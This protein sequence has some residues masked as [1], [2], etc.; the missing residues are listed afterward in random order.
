VTRTG[1]LVFQVLAL[2]HDDE[3]G[4]CNLSLGAL[5]R[6][7]GSSRNAV[8]KGIKSLEEA[9]YI[10]KR[11]RFRWNTERRENIPNSYT[12][13]GIPKDPKKKGGSAFSEPPS[14]G[15]EKALGGSAF[16]EPGVVQK[17]HPTTVRRAPTPP[18]A[19]VGRVDDQ[20]I[21]VEEPSD[22]GEERGKRQ[23]RPEPQHFTARSAA[24]TSPGDCNEE[25]EP[26]PAPFSLSEWQEA[27]DDVTD[28]DTWR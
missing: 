10:K 14:S 22:D 24:R 11:H 9:G 17:M 15:V 25:V 6:Q 26:G 27:A 3:T 21:L 2:T 8:I 4:D 13:L 19:L 23:S 5:A 1:K 18:N 28:P 20:P 16:S 7:T 12:I